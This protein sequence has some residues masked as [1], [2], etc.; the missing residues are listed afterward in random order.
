ML[1]RM[2]TL[3]ASAGAAEIAAVALV[4]VALVLAVLLMGSAL[5]SRL[6]RTR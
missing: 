4:L 1:R 5:A 6:R 3:A 2:F